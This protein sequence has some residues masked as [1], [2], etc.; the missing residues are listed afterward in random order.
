MLVYALYFNTSLRPVTS[1]LPI[2]TTNTAD[3]YAGL[4]RQCKA[5]GM[6]SFFTALSNIVNILLSRE[7]S[8]YLATWA[9]MMA[10]LAPGSSTYF[11]LYNF[12]FSGYNSGKNSGCCRSAVWPSEATENNN[13]KVYAIFSAIGILA[14]WIGAGLLENMYLAR[15]TSEMVWVEKRKVEEKENSRMQMFLN[16][17]RLTK[18]CKKDDLDKDIEME[19]NKIEDGEHKGFL[20]DKDQEL[21][22]ESDDKVKG[23]WIDLTTG[24]ASDEDAEANM[25]KLRKDCEVDGEKAEVDASDNKV[26]ESAIEDQVKLVRMS[27]GFWS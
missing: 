4:Q 2:T 26:G 10:D 14:S 1:S 7:N 25:T 9:E 12:I 3:Y 6:V 22:S 15:D 27:F 11:E 23:F 24:F 19:E 5:I 18:C 8:S 20:E 21:K 17:F 16:Q 13:R